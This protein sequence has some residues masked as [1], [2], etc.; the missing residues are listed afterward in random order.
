LDG[1]EVDCTDLSVVRCCE[2]KEEKNTT[3]APS[4]RISEEGVQ[5]TLS[6]THF[7]I[8]HRETI[9]NHTSC[10]VLVATMMMNIDEDEPLPPAD[11]PHGHTWSAAIVSGDSDGSEDIFEETDDDYLDPDP[12]PN[13][14]NTTTTGTNPEA[15][16]N[17]AAA[18][19]AAAD[20]QLY[21]RNLDEEDEA[22]VYKHLRGG[23]EETVTVKNQTTDTNTSASTTTAKK[24]VKIYKPRT[25][26][27]VLSCP[28][29]FNIVCMDCQRHTRYTNQFRAMFVMGITVDWHRRLRYEEAQQALV[30]ITDPQQEQ[31]QQQ[32]RPNQVVPPEAEFIPPFHQEDGEYFAVLCETCKTQVAALDM[33]EELYHFH[34][35][36]ES[37]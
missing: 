25:S 17:A 7:F 13:T 35:C 24:Q 31:Q 29:C 33:K 2:K 16:T 20:D 22:Y 36:L 8:V 5:V 23:V 6:I 12:D 32:D 14:S 10:T 4:H 9:S 28:C 27:A 30:V 11:P 1:A 37:A 26:D 19:A 21:D 15:P 3:V 18:A 34:G